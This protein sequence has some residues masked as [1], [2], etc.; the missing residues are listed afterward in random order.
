MTWSYRVDHS[1]S[2]STIRGVPKDSIPIFK[3]VYSKSLIPIEINGFRK[4]SY[5]RLSLKV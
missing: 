5:V 1:S 3:L 2:L 4:H